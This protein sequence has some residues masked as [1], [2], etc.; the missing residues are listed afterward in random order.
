MIEFSKPINQLA[1]SDFKKF[2]VWE[3]KRSTD[4]DETWV[5]PIKRIP[6]TKTIGRIIATEVTLANG[7][8]R[9][10]LIGN[11]D[12]GNPRL[13]KHFATVSIMVNDGRFHLT[14]YHDH[15]YTDRGPDQLAKFLGLAKE[16]VFPISYDLRLLDLQSNLSI[17]RLIDRM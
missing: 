4:G 8:T 15:D 7:E 11:V 12:A 1:P 16:N 17:C 14:R 6:V 9:W 10:A 5:R 2:K 13:T 3:Y